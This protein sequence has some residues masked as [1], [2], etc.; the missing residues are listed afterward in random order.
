MKP[1]R[2]RTTRCVSV[3]TIL[4]PCCHAAGD[5]Y[6]DHLV[7]LQT[8]LETARDLAVRLVRL[9]PDQFPS[10]VLFE[11]ADSHISVHSG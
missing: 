7:R 4:L 9:V 3:C 1:N 2:M 8:E 5:N 10:P 6:W 11:T